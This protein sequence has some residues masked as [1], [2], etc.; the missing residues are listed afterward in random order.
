MA[1]ITR[2]DTCSGQVREVRLYG[3]LGSKFG[4]KFML[5][6]D[7]AAEAS[8]ALNAQLDG[9]GKF[10]LESKDKGLGYA[11]FYGKRN[12]GEDDLQ[13]PC[14][15]DIIRIAPVVLGHKNGGWLQVI[16]G[17]V[18]FA[19]G[20][21][22]FWAPG[23]GVAL[24]QFGAMMMIGGVIQLLTPVPKGVGAKDSPENTPSSVFNGPVNTMAQGHNVPVIYG[25]C[26]V[27]SRVLS[28]GITAVDQAIIP[29][30][31]AV[32]GGGTGSGGGGGGG[33]P[34]WHG[35]YLEELL[36]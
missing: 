26:K 16:L 21:F 34:P 24:M 8:A 35:E 29:T 12:I 33:A 19:A 11:V 14:T 5:A 23:V 17:A 10:L 7:S 30:G 1:D 32:G 9:F 28:A 13:S 20:L 15:E 6:V 22:L 36:P 18:I 25:R 2:L 4:R 31:V 3:K 27:G